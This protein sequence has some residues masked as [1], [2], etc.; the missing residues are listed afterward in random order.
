VR[1]LTTPQSF[2]SAGAGFVSGDSKDRSIW[3]EYNGLRKDDAY[4]LLDFGYVKRDEA[5]GTWTV[6]EG[7]NLGLESRE[8]RALYG[9]QGNW[10]VFGEY[11]ENVKRDPRTV[12]TGLEGAGT[13]NPIVSRLAVPGTG[14]DIDLKLERKRLGI[15]GEKWI[16]PNLLFELTFQNEDKDGAR[17][18]GRGFNCPSAAAPTPVCTALATGANQWAILFLPE[19]VNSRTQQWEAKLN[20]NTAS[21]GLT[22]AYYGSFYKND[23]GTLVPTVTGNLNN[24]LG[25]PM[26]PVLTAGLRNILQL[27]MALPPDNQANQ[28]SLAG[29][30]RITPTTIATFKYAYTHATQHEDWASVGLTGAPGGRSDLGGRLDTTLAQA[31][32]S[33]RPL[34]KLQILA[35]VKYEDRDD[36]TPIEL[37]NIEGTSTFTNG[38]ISNTKV[39]G[40]LEASY[41][42]PSNFRATAGVDYESIDR[43]DF[44][45][46]S[47]VAGLSALRRKVYDRGYRL[48]LRRTM[49]E[50]LTGFVS[51]V[52]TKRDGSSW[53]KP[54]TDPPGVLPADPDCT[55]ATVNNVPNACIFSRTG[56]FPYML[57]NR[58][59]DKIRTIVDWSPAEKL[60][61]Q[62][63]AD[64][65]KDKYDNNPTEKG[66]R[67]NDVKLFSVDASYI[68]N[69]AWRVTGY[70]SFGEQTLQ[71][72][73]S[74]GYIADLKD[75]NTT[76][77]IGVAGRVSPRLK[78]GADLLYIRDRNI[79]DQTLDAQAS[80][81]NIAFLAQSGGLPEVVF[82]DTRLKVYGSYAV[83][84]N[85]DV[86]L[87]VVH[88]RTKLDEWTWGANGVAFAFSDNTTVNLR[89][90][91][92]VTFVALMYV[93]RFR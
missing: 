13:T 45:S 16:T 14:N 37:Y 36:K 49:S 58:D 46:T 2:V 85:A 5:T 39:N 55:S 10:R 21:M 74:T 40:K 51:Y 29:N 53:L 23:N 24:P 90:N 28:F 56:I 43:G 76:A 11:W 82:R 42:L 62:F 75:K 77:G 17:M 48:E 54:L 33:A 63:A 50:S 57:E 66:L 8:L 12:N 86:K 71:V 52:H 79:Y 3:G 78:L 4:F 35:N 32:V 25:N 9:P 19:P 34:A 22:A 67:N 93:Y 31:G 47:E 70:A 61:L 1:D 6:V 87:E 30:Y 88:D 44:V 89:P 80:A 18:F 60:T 38:H 41:S 81:A 73:H 84:K 68:L 65:G 7:R 64:Y 91:Q 20:Y 92:N 26:S 27:P 59:R 69:D 83:Q 15:G 72:A